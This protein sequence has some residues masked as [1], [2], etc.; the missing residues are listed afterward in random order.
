MSQIL[1]AVLAINLHTGSS[2]S[3]RSADWQSATA[4]EHL[5]FHPPDS[6]DIG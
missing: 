6:R 1:G 4:R 2:S 5:V 3:N